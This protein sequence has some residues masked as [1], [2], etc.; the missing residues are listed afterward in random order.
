MQDDRLIGGG[1]P[2]GLGMA[3]AENRRAWERFASMSDG[4]QREVIERTHS[5]ENKE[6]MKAL[7]MQIERGG[8]H[9]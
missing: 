6:D 9:P 5:I 3:L 7:V 2:L 1:I 4:E 8:F